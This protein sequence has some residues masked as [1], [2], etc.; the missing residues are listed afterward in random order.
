MADFLDALGTA[1]SNRISNRSQDVLNVLNNPT[2]YIQNRVENATTATNYGA[3]AGRGFVNPPVVVPEAP[4]ISPLPSPGVMPQIQGPAAPQDY[5]TRIAQQESG[6]NPNIGYHNKEKSSAY[7]PYGITSGAWADARKLDPN[8]PED[9]TQ[10]SQAQMTHAQNLFTKQN[11]GYLQNYGVPVNEQ[12][13]SAAHFLGAK[14][15]ADYLRDGTISPAAARANG[16]EE[17]VRKIVQGRLGGQYA[18]A[19]GAVQQTQ[20][21]AQPGQPPAPQAGAVAPFDQGEFA[22][23]DQAIATQAAQPQPSYTQPELDAAMQ[24]EL[25]RQ[26][27]YEALNGNDWKR[28]MALLE[29]PDKAIATQAA[30]NMEEMFKN[31]RMREYAQSTVDPMLARGEIPDTKRLKGEEGSYIKAYLFARL[32]LTD[33]AQQEQEKIS[34]TKQHMPVMVGENRYSAV[35]SKD[36]E[37]LSARDEAGKLVDQSTLS[38]IA[39][40]AMNPKNVHQMGGDVFSDPTGQVK[41]NFILETRPGQAPVFKRVGG[42]PDATAAEAASL[43]KT[44]VAGTLEY[45]QQQIEMK[46]R[47]RLDLL[48]KELQTRLEYIP[49]Q[50]H[51]K[52]I[53]K[54]NAEN[55]TN[56]GLMTGPG[57]KPQVIERPTTGAAAG[58]QPVTPPAGPAPAAVQPP[59]PAAPTA[60]ISPADVARQQGL[61]KKEGEAFVKYASEDITPKADAGSQVARIRK[62][63]INGPDG[64]LANPELAGL[65][66]GQGTKYDEIRNI[67]RDLVTGNYKEGGSDLSTRV[68]ALDLTQRQKDVL[69]TQIGLNTQLNP[70]TL[71][72]NAGPGAVS[73]AEHKLN[74]QANVDMTRQPLYSGLT[75]MSR[76]QF[77]ND[78][79]V[80]R[81]EFK[82][83]HPELATTSQ[84]NSAWN[85]E[86]SR[87]EKEYEAI[88][89]ERAKYIAQYNKDGKNPGAVVDAFKHY[90]VPEFDSQTGQW[91]YGAYSDKAKRPKLDSFVR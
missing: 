89:G 35:F 81:A 74:A 29:S 52:F 75:L 20:P 64:I 2:D 12:T 66:Q 19:S 82:N 27:D 76:S 40:N 13:L 37:L 77:I 3:G 87:L 8:L 79:S 44:G 70:L 84:F 61:A 68:A 15:L 32:G 49:A 34:P 26:K 39:A 16:G 21:Q 38:K 90:P 14:G 47:G 65:L 36:G 5:N 67:F 72:A 57:G 59:A 55:G 7:G 9:I 33:L 45:Q 51:N 43:K 30:A 23:L 62:Q 46:N 10:A 86:K 71:K 25:N 42:G 88:Y 17:A 50:E 80:A 22:G 78:L 69:N 11:A 91:T 48:N 85:K 53:S 41:G 4:A 6:N 58:A 28:T 1:L 24:A 54:F 18:P 83:Q 60:A 31:K 56:F 63:Q 73:E